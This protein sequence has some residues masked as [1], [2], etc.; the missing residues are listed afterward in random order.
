[1]EAARI[2]SFPDNF[3]F[4]GSDASA[5]HQ[6][7]NAIPPVLMWHI[8]KALSDQISDGG[9]IH[10]AKKERDNVADSLEEYSTRKKSVLTSA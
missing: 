10:K 3:K 4:T 8:A 9:H 5:Y 6:I 1:M 7:G 2:Q